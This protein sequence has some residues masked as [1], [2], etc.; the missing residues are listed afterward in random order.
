[1]DTNDELG[2]FEFDVVSI[3]VSYV[4]VE[5][6]TYKMQDSHRAVSLGSAI[7]RFSVLAVHA[8]LYIVM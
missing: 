2:H 3:Q 8:V 4:L 1:M 6:H 5:L 7:L